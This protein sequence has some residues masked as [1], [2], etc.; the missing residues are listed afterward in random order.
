MSGTARRFAAPVIV[1]AFNRPDYLRRVCLSL[2]AQRRREVEDGQVWLVQD[3]AVSP[4]TGVRYAEEAEINASIATFREVFP[5]GGV[6]DPS[7]RN[8]GIADNILRGERLAFQALR[9]EW[10]LFLEDDL[11][12]GPDYLEVMERI[13]ELTEPFPEV[14][15]FAAYGD[16]RHRY[17]PRAIE[18]IECDHHWAFGLRRSAWQRL[19][20]WLEPYYALLEGQDYQARR[21]LSILRW[22]A[23]FDMATDKSSQDAMKMLGCAQLGLTRVMT[24]ITFGRYIG[25]R[26]AHFSADQFQQLGYQNTEVATLD[27]REF[28]PFDQAVSDRIAAVTRE[29]CL[30]FRRNGF[31]AF[32]ERFAGRN[33]D[34]ERLAT[35]A[36][37]DALYGTLLDRLPENETIYGKYEGRSS[38]LA[39]R[40]T[41]MDSAEFRRKNPPR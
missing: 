28:W 13:A 33:F 40:R 3:G 4:R 18:W 34:P 1:F 14:A 39:L 11:E 41:I 9:A 17:D 29:R 16:H 25:E 21:H 20:G 32:F 35:R 26:G 27:G 23:G 24:N 37:I 30:S 7:G 5:G 8:H 31:D 15:Y 10:A 12:L 6:L 2:R 22:Q 19:H 38:V 36:E